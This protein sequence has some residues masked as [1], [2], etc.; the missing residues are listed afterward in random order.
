MRDATRQQ[1][2]RF[3][4]ARFVKFGFELAVFR[5]V[6]KD[7]HY[8]DDAVRVIMDR[9]AEGHDDPFAAR[10]RNQHRRRAPAERVIGLQHPFDG[11]VQRLA[12]GL[13]QR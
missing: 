5:D 1:A 13:V 4:L 3:Q 2:E 11:I 6:A 12:R 8:A 10:S 7:E 9:R